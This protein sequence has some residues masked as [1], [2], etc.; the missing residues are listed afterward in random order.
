MSFN[1]ERKEYETRQQKQIDFVLGVAI[2]IGINVVMVGIQVA[3][4]GAAASASQS[5]N[6][7]L[8]TVVNVALV[9]CTILHRRHRR[10][11][12]LS[13]LDGLRHAGDHR[14]A[15]GAGDLPGHRADRRVQHRPAQQPLTHRDRTTESTEGTENK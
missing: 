15:D 3:L 8:S 7:A 5:T 13:P 4:T 6:P 1:F 11:G 10:P 2:W 9:V 14:R 12:D